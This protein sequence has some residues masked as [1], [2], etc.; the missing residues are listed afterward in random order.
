MRGSRAGYVALIAAAGLL[1]GCAADVV[2]ENPRTGD[3]VTCQES[4]NGL[5]PWSQKEACV[6]AYTA[7]GWKRKVA[8]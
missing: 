2:M 5:N 7:Q 6:G 3:T 4:V 8:E 1:S